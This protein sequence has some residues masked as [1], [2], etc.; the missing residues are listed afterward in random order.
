MCA[1]TRALVMLDLEMLRIVARSWIISPRVVLPSR[2]G[3]LDMVTDMTVLMSDIFR[4]CTTKFPALR[5][6]WQIIKMRSSM[7]PRSR[8]HYPIVHLS[9]LLKT[10]IPNKT[11]Q[12][13]RAINKAT[14]DFKNKLHK[15]KRV[16][17]SNKKKQPHRLR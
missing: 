13:I 7:C 14:M 8:L 2:A 12:A 10:M 3:I 15:Q 9:L 16:V 1:E 4:T 11:Q 6:H 5:C 17:I